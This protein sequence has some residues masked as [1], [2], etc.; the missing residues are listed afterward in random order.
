MTERPAGPGWWMGPDG[1]WYLPQE[2]AADWG[3]QVVVVE[4]AVAVPEPSVDDPGP[5]REE[6]RSVPVGFGCA[7]VLLGFAL[8]VAVVVLVA[9]LIMALAG[10]VRGE[11][12]DVRADRDR[13]HADARDDAGAPTCSRNEYDDLHAEVV[14]T[15][16]SSKRSRYAVEVEF[17]AADG[18]HLDSSY[19]TV[20]RAE[21]GQSATVVIDT[22]TQ[23]PEGPF[24]CRVEQVDR[25]ADED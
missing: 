18:E 19:D 15:N 10:A 21:P 1:R 12:D 3:D 25:W 20:T 13:Q 5:V 9:A 24:T 16:D 23:A 17:L 6:R 7:V 14:V 4:Q 22:L 11:I 2:R 8:L